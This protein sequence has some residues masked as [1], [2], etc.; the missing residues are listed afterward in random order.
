MTIT[1]TNT[2]PTTTDNDAAI[3]LGCQIHLRRDHGEWSQVR[4]LDD[5]SR[6][7]I[8]RPCTVQV[9]RILDAVES[10]AADAWI[11]RVS[12]REGVMPALLARLI[13]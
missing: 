10:G 8:L 4:Y 6:R 12:E 1:I 11:E 2:M 3:A 9:I 5:G 13:G 7:S